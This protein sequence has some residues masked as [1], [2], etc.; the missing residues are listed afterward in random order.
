MQSKLVTLATH[1]LVILAQYHKHYY[2]VLVS[3][4]E[5]TEL[6]SL[7]SFNFFWECGTTQ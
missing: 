1:V 2:L 6:P 5:T 3:N 7:N 4:Y